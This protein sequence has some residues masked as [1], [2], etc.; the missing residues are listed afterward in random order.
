MEVVARRQAAGRGAWGC[1]LILAVGVAGSTARGLPQTTVTGAGGSNPELA[2]GITV[3]V[4]NYARVPS[5]VLVGAE[6]QTAKIFGNSGVATAWLDCCLSAAEAGTPACERPSGAADLNLQLL[7]PSMAQALAPDHDT[8]GIALT[9][10]DVP[11]AD[12]FIFY[13]RILDLAK[14][15]YVREREILAAV[16]TH[17]IGHLLLGPGHSPSGI[18]RAKWTWDELEMVRSGLLLFTPDQSAL[19]RAEALAR[20]NVSAGQTTVLSHTS[21]ADARF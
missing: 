2:L 6:R 19:L 3:R 5:P 16:M 20:V 4:Y 14:T 7:A 18:M 8:F 1:V 10:K 11:A 17:E 13:G 9:V 12:A 15:G 21:F